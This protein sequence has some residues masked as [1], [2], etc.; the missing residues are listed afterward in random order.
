VVEGQWWLRDGVEHHPAVARS[1]LPTFY[2]QMDVFVLPSLVEGFPL[3]ALEAMACGLPVVVSENTFGSDV[4]RD[5]YNGYVVPIRDVDAI[6]DRLRL[7]AGDDEL[8][9]TMGANARATAES[10][11]WKA[12]NDRLVDLVTR[13]GSAPTG[14]R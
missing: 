6:V 12:F 7:L 13:R 4:I 11:S 14:I 9:A 2:A 1:T 8:R 5:G 10:F 3:T